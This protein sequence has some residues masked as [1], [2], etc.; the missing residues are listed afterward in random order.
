MEAASQ[1][2]SLQNGHKRQR[3]ERPRP[4]LSCLECKRKKIKCNRQLPC[5]QCRKL[6]ESNKAARCV[7]ASPPD[8]L[9]PV[10][11]DSRAEYQPQ[12]PPPSVSSGGLR[13]QY[14]APTAALGGSNDAVIDLQHRVANIERLLAMPSAAFTPAASHVGTPDS[15]PSKSGILYLKKGRVRY[16]PPGF[17]LT[18]IMD[19]V[20]HLHYDSVLYR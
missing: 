16:G 15:L 20:S 8:S 6:A 5:N 14:A 17:L 7:Y 3:L 13:T 19:S 18:L 12:R 2:E 11:D 4:L 10:P 9:S 1:P